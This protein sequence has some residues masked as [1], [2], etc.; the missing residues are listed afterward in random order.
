MVQEDIEDPKNALYLTPLELCEEQLQLDGSGI[1]N[2]AGG[3]IKF[4]RCIGTRVDGLK[5]A[6]LLRRT[7]GVDVGGASNEDEYCKVALGNV[8]DSTA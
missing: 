1:D 5:I 3:P 8:Q 7:M 2:L 6:F 4:G